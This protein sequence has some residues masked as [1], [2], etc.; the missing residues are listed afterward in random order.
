MH[1]TCFS[2]SKIHHELIMDVCDSTI[3]VHR[4]KK[5]CQIRTRTSLIT[6]APVG[7]AHQGRMWTQQE[8]KQRF[9]KA[10]ESQSEIRPLNQRRPSQ[11]YATFTTNKFIQVPNSYITEHFKLVPTLK[12][13]ISM[14]SWIT[15]KKIIV[16]VSK[17]ATFNLL[18]PS[19]F[20][21]FHQV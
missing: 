15:L 1:E 19:G 16:S 17:W 11:V 10:G 21:T 14:C 9:S 4:L 5:W 7:P 20:F 2:T 18:K 13:N 3:R 6:T 12:T 8:W